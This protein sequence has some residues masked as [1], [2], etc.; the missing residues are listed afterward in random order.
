MIRAVIFD[1]DGVLINT[2]PLHYQCWVELFR[3]KYG[4][5]LDYE[6][7]KPCIG[8]T[9]LHFMNLMKE[10]YGVVFESLEAMNQMMKEKKDE[11]IARDGFPEMP[12]VGVMLKQL[13]E[14]GYRLAVAS[15]SP[16]DVI[17]ETLTSLRLMKYFDVVTSGDE[18]K[19]P[20]PAPD[21]FL[22]AAEQLQVPAEECL[23]IED[24]TNGGKAAEA[25]GM[26][27]IWMHNPDSGD[28]EISNPMFEITAW[29]PENRKR[30]MEFLD[31]DRKG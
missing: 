10:H 9:R 7:Y 22:Y 28:Q 27:C 19:N 29:T 25:A 30:V 31:S 24:S 13:K 6:V 5:E 11:I 20:K 8:S 15:S 14:E 2:E 21:T 26:S 1:M 3:E 18:V 4:K 23:V 17:E 16:K 12:G